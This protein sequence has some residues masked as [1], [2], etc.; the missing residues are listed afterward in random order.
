MSRSPKSLTLAR[1]A[2]CGGPARAASSRTS[3]RSPHTSIGRRVFDTPAFLQQP[4]LQ[5]LI[6]PPL[7][8]VWP[9]SERDSSPPK[10]WQRKATEDSTAIGPGPEQVP[11]DL[12]SPTARPS[13]PCARRLHDRHALA[14]SPRN[15]LRPRTPRLPRDRLARRPSIRSHPERT[16]LPT[17]NVTNAP[18]IRAQRHRGFNACMAK[19]SFGFNVLSENLGADASSSIARPAA[20][21]VADGA[22][23]RRLLH[24]RRAGARPSRLHRFLRPN[25]EV[26][27][28]SRT[29]K[30]EGP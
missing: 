1:A 27:R 4:D 28:T 5:A 12:P 3:A 21:P 13:R 11:S 18:R 20:G 30:G 14:P 2:R 15:P 22:P 25:S 6:A 19:P 10:A 9:H 17:A 16:T 23:H 7:R 24:S 29:T 8:A 26:S